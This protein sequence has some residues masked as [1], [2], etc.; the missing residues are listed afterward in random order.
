MAE[1]VRS[2]RVPRACYELAA[3]GEPSVTVRQNAAR[4]RYEFDADGGEALAF[5]RLVTA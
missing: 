2:A 5:Y 1:G 3:T 4:N